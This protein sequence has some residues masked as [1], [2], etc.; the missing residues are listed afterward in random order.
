LG[1]ELQRLHVEPAHP[2][3]HRVHPRSFDTG[4]KWPPRDLHGHRGELTGPRRVIG[5]QRDTRRQQLLLQLLEVHDRVRGQPQLVAAAAAGQC[6]GVDP[7]IS[8]EHPDPAHHVA[9]RGSPGARQGLCPQRV[10]QLL[11]SHGAATLSDKQ[12]ED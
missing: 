6:G 2:Q 1:R 8:Q 12:R 7:G 9:Q 5:L 11:P 3:P 4:Q 10:R